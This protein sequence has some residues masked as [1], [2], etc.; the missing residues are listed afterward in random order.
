MSSEAFCP[1]FF[2]FLLA[3]EGVVVCP[4]INQ[5]TTTPKMGEAPK[6]IHPTLKS[7]VIM[8]ALLDLH[9]SS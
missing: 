8:G 1:H 7:V 2:H 9:I 5:S 3:K 4:T 6:G